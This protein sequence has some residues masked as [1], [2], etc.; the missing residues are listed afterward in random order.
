MAVVP[1]GS[2]MRKAAFGVATHALRLLSGRRRVT[3]LVGAGNNGGDALWAG[4]FLRRRG[5]GVSAILLNPAKAHAEGLSAFRRAG[6]RIVDEVGTPDLVIDGIVGLSARGPLRPD[7]AALV[8]SVRAPILAVDLPSGIDPDTGE[9]SGPFVRA[10]TTVTFGCLKPVHALAD[11]GDVHLVDIGLRPTDPDF[12]L[13]DRSD[14]AWPVPGPSD[15]KY[16]QGVTGVAA[17]SATYPGA[18]VLSTGAAVLATSG[19][20][21]YAGP[22]ADAIRARWPETICTGSITDAGRVQ[23]WVVGPGMGTGSSS[24]GVLRSVL[25]AG[26]PVIADAD[27]ITLLAQHPTLWDARDPDTPL[28]LTPHDREFERLAG[29]VGV[30]RVAAAR[31]A[32]QRFNA[33]VLLKGHRTVVA[34]PDGRALVNS[35]TSSWP[36]TAGSGDVLSG[37]IGALLAGGVEPFLAAG[38]AAYAHVLAA[39]LAAD[40]APVPASGLMEAIPAAV[41]ALRR[42]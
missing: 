32:A 2:L 5:V 19:M 9:I 10:H 22:A 16:T 11:C 33:V 38:Y 12:V 28:V 18:A 36:A 21:R 7:A 25:E 4:Y 1:P 35:A 24:D 13:L 6:G 31:K 37:I 41:R 29:P 23:A 8:E 42:S 26:V 17:G 20:V 34:A 30:D 3:L 39:E 40:G 27:A 15:D 14:I